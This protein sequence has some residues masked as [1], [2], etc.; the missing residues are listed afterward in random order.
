M[1]LTLVAGTLLGAG[2]AAAADTP[3]PGPVV[4][5]G[6]AGLQ[7][8]DVGT[9]TPALDALLVNGSSAALVPRSVELTACPVDGWLAV[10]AGRRADATRTPAGACIGPPVQFSRPAGPATVTT[11]PDITARAAD[12]GFDARPGTLGDSLTGRR[13]AAL[14]PGAVVALARSDGT[15]PVAWADEQALDAALVTDPEVLVIDLGPLTA[16]GEPER[17]TALQELDARLTVILEALPEEA[18]VIVASIADDPAVTLA[19]ADGSAG[20]PVPSEPAGS[21]GGPSGARMQL[22]SIVGPAPGGGNHPPSLLR[23]PST[24]HDGLV[25]TT[26]LAPTVLDLLG[27]ALPTTMDGSPWRAAAPSPGTDP[28]EALA[29]RLERLID[30]D[31]SA[32]E[33]QAVVGPFVVVSVATV[34]FAALILVALTRVVPRG[35][36]RR[37]VLATL[38]AVG[39]AGGCLPAA[40]LLAALVPWWRSESAAATL[41]LVVTGWVGLLA[42]VA[43]LGPWRRQP[44]GPAGA[45]GAL[46]AI[47]LTADVAAGSPLS[48]NTVMGGQ[49]LIAGRFYGFGNP[50]FAVFAAAVLVLAMAVAHAMLPH[51][52][53]R[54]VAAVAAL[55]LVAAVIDVLPSLGADVGGGPALIP[56]FA[57]LAL[58]LS[59]LQL[60]W[61]RGV[62]V[63]VATVALIAG[64]AVADWLRAPAER[65]HL[66]RFVQTALDGGAWNVI[67]RK[68]SQN[69]EILTSSPVTLIIPVVVALAVWLLVDPLR[70]R[71]RP[72]H[73]A[74]QR[75][76][77]LTHGLVALGVMLA[78]AFAAN[79]SGTSIPPA[80]GLLFVPLLVA[81]SARAVAD[82]D[83]LDRRDR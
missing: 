83:P 38:H 9:D 7:W 22:T 42:S 10:S 34:L 63:A 8:E 74:Y 69:L 57:V 58:R 2:A 26:D 24:R 77:V 60:T 15:A 45:V 21:A 68:A 73:T 6:T 5:I 39:I 3:V 50:L 70:F 78:I 76:P 1:A 17:S 79:D 56:A 18:T 66:G 23:S 40:T 44:L 37:R 28:E 61:R 72:L 14:G 46:T 80:A 65:T 36:P 31:L 54:T 43:L 4:L 16:A 35:A 59:G 71:L 32:V 47:A 11:W 30:L 29:D 51:G 13:T 62:L 20:R 82:E 67:R 27:V 55:G 81:V 75:L 25:L 19:L 41:G 64:V 52:T 48:L 33:L 53:G 12:Q 49:P